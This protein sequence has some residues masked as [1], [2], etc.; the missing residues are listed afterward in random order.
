MLRIISDENIPYAREAF[1]SLGE[2]KTLPG[3]QLQAADL[4]ECDV[5]L[6]RSVTRVDASLLKDSPVQY[7]ASATIGTD[8]IDLE[9]LR[10][11]GIGFSNAPG[12]NAES[13]SEYVLH[14]LLKLCQLQGRDPLSL[15]AGI[16]GCGNVGSRLQA[17]LA[18]LGIETLINDPPLQAQGD[19]R[20]NYVTLDNLLEHC[21]FISL[22]VPLTRAGDWPTFHLLDARKLAKLKTNALLFNAARG[23]VIDNPALNTLLQQRDDLTVYLDCWEGEPAISAELLQRV[24]W[25]TPHIAGYSVEGKLR[26]T[27]MI[28][29]AVAQ[30]FGV[31]T[32]WSLQDLLPSPQLLQ[33]PATSNTANLLL[34]LLEQIYPLKRD[35]EALLQTAP[36]ASESAASEF[37]R[38]RKH[39]PVRYEWDRFIVDT[40]KL[41]A[42]HQH[43]FAQLGLVT[44]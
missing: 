1:A 21:D 19:S 4:H 20:F 25:G 26:G 16:I 38:L 6:V 18:A 34:D 14:T 5:L 2:V 9:Y 3:R 27:E 31:E 11:R 39:Y 22:H 41:E 36:L 10:Q 44:Q 7:V 30:H 40:T 13:A 17:K 12:C 15:R 28:Q 35:Y 33:T 24:D 8:H 42:A 43:I 29:H 37:D 32:R 23:A